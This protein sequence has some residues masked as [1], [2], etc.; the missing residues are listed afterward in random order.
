MS[1]ESGP[2]LVLERFAYA[3]YGTYG[4][5][6]ILPEHWM[7]TVER[8][9]L[10][11]ERFKSCI[12]EGEYEVGPRTSS[13]FGAVMEVMNV[14]NRTD[15]LFHAANWPSSLQGCISPGL[16][17]GFL[18][19]GGQFCPAVLSSRRAMGKL[20]EIVGRSFSLQVTS[21]RRTALEL[22][23]A[24]REALIPWLPALACG[25]EGA[26]TSPERWSP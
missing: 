1:V 8:E 16:G 6:L 17:F 23:I 11:N 9:W 20:K 26:K 7:W 12:P 13:R 24:D 15:I 25:H 21:R 3:P 2:P 10:D 19:S 5:L 14:P 22:G 18:P 4:R